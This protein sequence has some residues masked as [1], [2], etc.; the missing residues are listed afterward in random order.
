MKKFE[1]SLKKVLEYKTNVEEKEKVI[2]AQLNS[3]HKKLS[4]EM[5]A[6]KK[7]Y[8][9]LKAVY[10]ETCQKGAEIREVLLLRSYMTELEKKIGQKQREVADAEREIAEQVKK[11]I[12]ISKEKNTMEKLKERHL[13]IYKDKQRKETELFIDNF[14]T[15]ANQNGQTKE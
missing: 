8:A 3:Q 1:F 15:N 12:E 2:L 6:L 11:I 9:A 7:E 10:E 13:D 4:S 14:I 5:E